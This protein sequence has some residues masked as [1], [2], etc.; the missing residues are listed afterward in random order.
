MT[1]FR[2]RHCLCMEIEF[3]NDDVIKLSI[4]SSRV[5]I[6]LRALVFLWDHVLDL[7]FSISQLAITIKKCV[8]IENPSRLSTC[9]S[10]APHSALP[11]PRVRF[12]G[13]GKLDLSGKSNARCV[14]WKLIFEIWSLCF[15]VLTTEQRTLKGR[16]PTKNAWAGKALYSPLL[17]QLVRE[18]AHVRSTWSRDFNSAKPSFYCQ[19]PLSLSLSVC[20]SLSL[21]LSVCLAVK[22]VHSRAVCLPAGWGIHKIGSGK[23]TYSFD[24][25][26]ERH[27]LM[28]NTSVEWR[29]RSF[30]SY[31]LY[32]DFTNLI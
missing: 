8:F 21:S 3:S 26:L 11:S 18:T 27:R 1:S 4:S 12:W 16:R 25:T 13:G 23:W 6:L 24:L 9:F 14:K 32:S 22:K 20:L 29:Y 10:V 15:D 7:E 5:A 19:L 28:P 17:M 2:W 31:L 30:V